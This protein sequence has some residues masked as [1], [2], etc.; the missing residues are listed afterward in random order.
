MRLLLADTDDKLRKSVKHMLTGAHYVVDD[1]QN[2]ADALA[3]GKTNNYDGLILETNLPKMDGEQVLD[4]LRNMGVTTPILFLTANGDRDYAASLLKK[5]ADDYVTKPFYAPEFLA[6]I[7]AMLRRK[8]NFTP[9][10]LSY[11]GLYLDMS[12]LTLTYQDRSCVLGSKEAQILEIFLQKPE[13]LV[14]TEQIFSHIWGWNNTSE[15]SVVWV[16]ISN[17]RKKIRLMEAPFHIRYLRN[18]GYMLV[19]LEGTDMPKQET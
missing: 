2:G 8:D 13:A 10:I 7:G 12:T 3:F 1:V 16:H 18:A 14:P 15:I 11:R 9:T 19:C 4:N 6:R 17:L 5:G